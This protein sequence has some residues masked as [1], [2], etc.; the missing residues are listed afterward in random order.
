MT[1]ELQLFYFARL[2]QAVGVSQ[3]KIALPT[4]VACVQDLMHWLAHRGGAW[5][6]EFSGCR[7]L[8]AA[9]NQ[10]LAGNTAPISAGDEIAFFP[11]VTG[12]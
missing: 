1:T 7:P 10:T 12:G 9:I 6:E 2:R 3:E 4:D 11:P 5:Q 8:R